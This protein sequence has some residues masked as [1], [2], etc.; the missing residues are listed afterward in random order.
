[1]NKHGF[2]GVAQLQSRSRRKQGEAAND[3]VL[4]IS[5]LIMAAPSVTH[6]PDATTRA[7]PAS[8]RCSTRRYGRTGGELHQGSGSS[9]R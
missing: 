8:D 6:D 3:A 2:I 4:T 9:G 5:R 7:E 1:M